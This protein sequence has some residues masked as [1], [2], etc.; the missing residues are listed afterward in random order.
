MVQ[1]HLIGVGLKR[2]PQTLLGEDSRGAFRNFFVV[3][4]VAFF[5]LQTGR[6]FMPPPGPSNNRFAYA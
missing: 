4:S 6:D 5:R 1:M 3:A 2:M